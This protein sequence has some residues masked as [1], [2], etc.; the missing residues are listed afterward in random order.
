L[1]KSNA[2]EVSQPSQRCVL[3]TFHHIVGIES[4]D[5]QGTQ[6]QHKKKQPEMF[7]SKTRSKM[8]YFEPLPLLQKLKFEFIFNWLS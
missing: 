4:L 5:L 8:S 3:T 7:L 6:F 1:I 2:S